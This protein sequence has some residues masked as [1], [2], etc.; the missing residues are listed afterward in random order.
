MTKE[1]EDDKR[2]KNNLSNYF[3]YLSKRHKTLPDAGG[4][5]EF[6]I[7]APGPTCQKSMLF[8]PRS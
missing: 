8:Y 3:F 5:L 2:Q 4:R 7:I 1:P 6:L